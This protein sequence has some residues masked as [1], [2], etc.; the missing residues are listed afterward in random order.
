LIREQIYFEQKLIQNSQGCKED[1]KIIV[2][3]PD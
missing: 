3:P 1:S 2:T